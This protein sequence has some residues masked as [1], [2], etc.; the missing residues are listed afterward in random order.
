MEDTSLLASL[1]FNWVMY[2]WTSSWLEIDRWYNLKEFQEIAQI[3]L[4][5]PVS[6]EEIHQAARHLAGFGV[7]NYPHQ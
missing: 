3:E 5:R 1:L 2:H 4:G 6:L 7:I